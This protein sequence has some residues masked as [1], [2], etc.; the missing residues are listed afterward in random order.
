MTKFR[1]KLTA[2]FMLLIGLSVLAAGLLMG[3][4][5]QKNHLSA[6]KEHMIRELRVLDATAPWPAEGEASSQSA[7]LQQQARH[8]KEIAGMRVT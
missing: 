1:W 7:Y 6:L 5:Y 4:S 8:F 2:L 3:N